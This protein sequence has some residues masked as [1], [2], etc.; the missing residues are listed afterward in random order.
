MSSLLYSPTEAA[1]NYPASD[2]FLRHRLQVMEELWETVLRTECGQEMVDLLRQLRDLCSPEGQATQDQATE[3]FKL[4][5]Q[6]SI[7][8]AIRAA[9]AFALYFQLINIIE[10]DYEQRQ[11]MTKYEVEPTKSVEE[12]LPTI[13]QDNV[14][15]LPVNSGLGA[16]LLTKS[17]RNSTSNKQRGTFAALFPEL[18]KLNV[19]PQQIQRLITQ[20]DVQLVFSTLR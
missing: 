19:P 4:I 17:W 18:F 10:Q 8:E 14:E 6:L 1:N 3:V 9:R 15:G 5:E 11:Q 7:N 13:H 16:D 20:L 12:T 2:L